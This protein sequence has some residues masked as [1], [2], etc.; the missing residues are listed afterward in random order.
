VTSIVGLWCYLHSLSD[1]RLHSVRFRASTIRYRAS[2]R[3]R[4]TLP[5]LTRSLRSALP[6]HPRSNCRVSLG[7]DR[8]LCAL[9]ERTIV[10]PGSQSGQTK[11]RRYVHVC[12]HSTPKA[13]TRAHYAFEISSVRTHPPLLSQNQL[14]SLTFFYVWPA[15]QVFKYGVTVLVAGV[16]CTAATEMGIHG[17]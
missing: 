13:G 10:T 3:H 4:S 8:N 5:Q 1:S 17:A 14:L 7:R 6:M 15:E 2:L 12:I 11:V 9:R 16:W